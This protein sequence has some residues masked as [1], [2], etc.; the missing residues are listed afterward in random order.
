[1]DSIACSSPPSSTF[2]PAV[3]PDAF[4]RRFDAAAGPV[5]GLLDGARAEQRIIAFRGVHGYMRASSGPGWA[6]VGDAGYFKDPL[7]A[8]GITDALRDAECLAR[9]IL[10]GS[11]QALAAYAADRDAASTDLFAVTG[12][13]AGLDWSLEAVKEK[14]KRLNR[15]MREE[16]AWLATQRNRTARVPRPCCRRS[17][18][19]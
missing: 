13:I 12:E 7:T 2:D 15:A 8:H 17:T 1:M 16:Q 14:H 4:R 11:D 19:D 5:A 3:S 9:A 10:Q 18:R 6:L